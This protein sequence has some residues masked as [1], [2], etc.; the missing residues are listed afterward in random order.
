MTRVGAE[1]YFSRLEILILTLGI[2]LR[3]YYHALS[4]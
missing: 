2:Q 3:E 4:F 1:I